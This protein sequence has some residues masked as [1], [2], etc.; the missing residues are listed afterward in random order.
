MAK[1]L[2]T[3][4]KVNLCCLIP[5]SLGISTKFTLI[6]INFFCHQPIPSSHFVAAPF[7]F[8]T[9]FII[10]ILNRA[11]PFF[12]ARLFL[13]RCHKQVFL[14]LNPVK[15]TCRCRIKPWRFHICMTGFRTLVQSL[16]INFI[17]VY[18]NYLTLLS[19]NSIS[20]ASWQQSDKLFCSIHSTTVLFQYTILLII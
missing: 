11:T 20:H 10:A 8:T 18:I 16:Q 6:V 12:T 15:S 19:N 9:F 3:A 5:G 17:I 7:D 13:S 1:I 14:T 2:I 4:I